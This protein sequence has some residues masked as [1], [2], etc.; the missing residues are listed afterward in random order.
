MPWLLAPVVKDSEA[1]IT[2]MENLVT[3]MGRRYRLFEVNKCPH[4]DAYNQKQ[5]QQGQAPEPRIV[6]IFDEY[7]DFMVEKATRNSLEESIK[8]LGAMARAA[9]IHLI[10]ATQR[11]EAK[12]VTPIIRSNLPGRIALRTA[13]EADSKIILGGTRTEG[14]YLLGKGDLFFQ[15]GGQLQRLQSLFADIVKLPNWGNEKEAVISNKEMFKEQNDIPYKLAE[16]SRDMAQQNILSSVQSP[17]ASI[18]PDFS[19][20][21]PFLSHQTIKELLE[22]GYIGIDYDLVADTAFAAAAHKFKDK[23]KWTRTQPDKDG[24]VALMTPNLAEFDQLL[25]FMIDK[26]GW[27][28]QVYANEDSPDVFIFNPQNDIEKKAISLTIDGD[29]GWKGSL[30]SLD[31]VDVAEK[32]KVLCFIFATLPKDT[33]EQEWL[34]VQIE[35]QKNT[36]S[37]SVHPG[38]LEQV[39]YIWAEKIGIPEPK[40]QPSADEIVDA[41][42]SLSFPEII[43]DFLSTEYPDCIKDI[44]DE[45]YGFMSEQ[46]ILSDWKAIQANGKE[47]EVIQ[48]ATK[49]ANLVKKVFSKQLSNSK[50]TK[51]EMF[52]QLNLPVLKDIQLVDSTALGFA[53]NRKGEQLSEINTDDWGLVSNREYEIIRILMV[54]IIWQTRTFNF[55]DCS[56]ILASLT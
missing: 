2:L 53:I 10:V 56:M 42:Q 37:W 27:C 14:A 29:Y 15:V 33:P 45:N 36:Q 18:D 3:E 52:E 32:Q 55:E 54:E 49:W 43:K 34:L 47:Q 41:L 39:Y 24:D 12:V 38:T 44:F 1:A 22:K 23:I 25:D 5:I 35:Q 19:L 8:R 4:L 26:F 51:F 11:P 46:K 7:A 48:V 17:S 21:K 31:Y 50:L 16:L 40:F 28:P 20:K 6:C 30:Y 13:S 9:G